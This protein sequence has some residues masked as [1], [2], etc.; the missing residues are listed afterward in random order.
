MKLKIVYTEN[1]TLWLGSVW[2]DYETKEEALEK[3]LEGI[4]NKNNVEIVS[5]EVLENE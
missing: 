2:G 4:R 3:W 1:G 5:V